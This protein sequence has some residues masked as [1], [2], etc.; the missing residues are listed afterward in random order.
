M[1]A[2][3][4]VFKRMASILAPLF[5]TWLVLSS[6]Q[7]LAGNWQILASASVLSIISIL[8]LTID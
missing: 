2:P 3:L 5:V 4:L 6:Q 7:S 8:C 1:N